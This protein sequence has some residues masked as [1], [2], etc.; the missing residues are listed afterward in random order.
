VPHLGISGIDVKNPKTMES[1]HR[2]GKMLGEVMIRGNT[3]MKGYLAARPHMDGIINTVL[4]VVD[5]GLPCFSR[6][7]LFGNLRKQFHPEI[8]VAE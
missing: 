5:S 4:L 8:Q 1:V 2:D 7:D 6:G 3:V